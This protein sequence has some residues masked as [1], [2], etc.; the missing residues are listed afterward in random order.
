[1]NFKNLLLLL[2]F[3]SILSA[4]QNQTKN[5]ASETKVVEEKTLSN[6]SEE[7]TQ[8]QEAAVE[9]QDTSLT[10]FVQQTIKA[11]AKKDID[12]LV[13]L[14]DENGVRFS[15]YVNVSEDDQ[16]IL[17]SSIK[18]ISNSDSLLLWG[19]FDGS[20][21][22]IKLTFNAY[23]KRFVYNRDFINIEA[24]YNKIEAS[25]NDLNNLKTFYP[26]SPFVEFYFPGTTENEQMDW[27]AL[28]LVF[29]HQNNSYKLKAIIHNQWTI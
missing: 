15:P 20:G 26:K 12:K 1:M 23:F 13:P 2:L 29:S 27:K 14:M 18:A 22:D 7:L 9:K 3:V 24:K 28:Y 4:C 8:S 17:P 10:Y 11:L 21:E 25:G 6:N 5:P 19:V 16:I